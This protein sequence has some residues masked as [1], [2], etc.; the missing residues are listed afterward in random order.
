MRRKWLNKNDNKELIVFFNGWGAD[1]KAVSH[2]DYENYDVLVF[3]DYRNFDIENFR[4]S[5]YK[6]KYLT[7]WSMGVFVCNYFYDMF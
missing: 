6:S 7:A 2:L 5:S 3:Y 4:F 1:E